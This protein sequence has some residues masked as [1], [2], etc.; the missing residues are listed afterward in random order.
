MEHS[1]FPRHDEAREIAS[2]ITSN[3]FEGYPDGV[4]LA[5]PGRTGKSTF[6]RH[7]LIPVLEQRGDLVLYIDLWQDRTIDPAEMI[8]SCLADTIRHFSNPVMK[9]AGSIRTSALGF[10]G[11]SAN[12]KSSKNQIGTITNALKT[13]LKATE[14]N[15]VFIID[16]AQR[17]LET[18]TGLNAMYGLKAARDAINQGNSEFR[19]FLVMTGSDRDMLNSLVGGNK[20][21][22]FGS[23]ILEFSTMGV[24]FTAAITR[25]L[26]EIFAPDSQVSEKVVEESFRILGR[27]PGILNE[28]LR[29]LIHVSKEENDADLKAIVEEKRQAL[30][31]EVISALAGLS[32]LHVEIL[33]RMSMD[34]NVFSPFSEKTGNSLMQSKETGPPSVERIKEI[35]DDLREKDF[36]WQNL[37][38]TFV[39]ADSDMK[40]VLREIVE[41]ETNNESDIESPGDN[42][43]GL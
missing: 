24:E 23:G 38:G 32:D 10:M 3:P 35:M 6:L 36:V 18:E 28:C 33:K 30:N 39:L 11:A 31:Q 7:Y 26:N 14:K 20:A 43:P 12:F 37:Y 22:F 17:S 34:D 4:F 2:L 15:I 25:Q 21:P 8:N 13:I 19:L 1:I 9:I 40:N 41:N 5:A 29:D 16:E 27:R 42:I